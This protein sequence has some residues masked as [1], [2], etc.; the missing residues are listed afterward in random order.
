MQALEVQGPSRSFQ[1]RIRQPSLTTLISRGVRPISKSG[2]QILWADWPPGE[3][4]E[5]GSIGRYLQLR[6]EEEKLFAAE[7]PISESSGS[8]EAFRVF[9]EAI[10]TSRRNP[11]SSCH[12]SGPGIIR[13]PMN[14]DLACLTN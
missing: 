14:Y 4:T 5:D 1:G 2:R 7:L 6:L 9:L 11:L 10:S 8:L 13:M 3:K 12:R